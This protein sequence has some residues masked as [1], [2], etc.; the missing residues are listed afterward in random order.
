MLT[1]TSEC[2]AGGTCRVS[3]KWVIREKIVVWVLSALAGLL[4]VNVAIQMLYVRLIVRRFE[5]QPPFNVTSHAA[6][7]MAEQVSTRTAD[8]LVLRGSLHRGVAHN[9]RGLVYFCPELSGSHWSASWYC[10]GLLNAGFDV[11]SFDFRGQG[12]SECQPGYQ[13]NHWPTHHEI[14]DMDA[15]LQFIQQREDLRNLP[16][17]LMGVSR[18]S[19]IALQTAARVPQVQAVCGDSTYSVDSLL[20]HF[21]LRWAQLYLSPRLLRLIPM[22]HLR[23]T[24]RM[25]RWWSA[26]RRHVQ[27]VVVEPKLQKLRSRPVLLISGERDNYVPPSIIRGLAKR[28]ASPMCRIWSVPRAKH[29]QAREVDRDAYD[30]TVEQFFSIVCPQTAVMT[31]ETPR[32][33]V[34]LAAG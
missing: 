29:N 13:P 4:L 24:L 20:E 1:Q 17:V 8:G 15:A 6:D 25:V 18:G 28:L 14:L 21:T 11:L 2:Y 33:P 31:T 23:L 22:W 3:G 9:P 7:P 32:T 12:D 27:Y 5:A 10:D 19:L 16:L 26:I 34:Q 30:Q